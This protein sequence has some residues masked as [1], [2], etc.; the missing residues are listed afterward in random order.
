MSQT[1]GRKTESGFTMVELAVVLGLGAILMGAGVSNLHSLS[2]TLENSASQVASHFKLV[3]AKAVSNTSAYIV[4]P[5]SAFRI[6]VL[7]ADNCSDAAPVKDEA[8]TL[9]LPNGAVITDTAWEVCF[10]SRG[11]PDRS[12]AISLLDNDLQTRDVEIFLGGAIRKL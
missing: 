2:N 11:L 1:T 6:E 5:A 10:N 12:L 7:E 4:R 8:M 3:R 9:N